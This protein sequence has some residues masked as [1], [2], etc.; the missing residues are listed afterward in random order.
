LGRSLNRKRG[1]GNLQKKTSVGSDT[2]DCRTDACKQ[3]TTLMDEAT[4]DFR[5][6]HEDDHHHNTRASTH[7]HAQVYEAPSTLSDT[8][9]SY[10]SSFVR[11]SFQTEGSTVELKEAYF[12]L[13]CIMYPL[14]KKRS[15]LTM[16][17]TVEN[18]HVVT[19]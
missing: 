10:F 13:R 5:F 15:Y 17:P 14:V 6:H 8:G 18:S 16:F 12:A 19:T 2:F 1:L 3:C 11:L 4:I 7:A 9:W